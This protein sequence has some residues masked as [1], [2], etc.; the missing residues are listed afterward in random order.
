L[1]LGS[2]TYTPGAGGVP[3]PTITYSNAARSAATP[4][5]PPSPWVVY[6]PPGLP[7]TYDA[8]VT[9]IRWAFTGSNINS[10]NSSTISFI[11]RIK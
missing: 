10:G 6:T 5:Q 7:G 11:V 4:P 2:L 3:A 9:Y 8:Q 1:K